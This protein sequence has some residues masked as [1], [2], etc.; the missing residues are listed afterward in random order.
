MTP[1]PESP[2]CSVVLPVF[3]EAATVAELHQRLTSALAQTLQTYEIIYVN[4]GSTDATPGMLDDLAARDSRVSVVHLARNFGQHAALFAG[5]ERVRGEN[6]VT[7]DADLQNPPEEIPK[8]LSRLGADVDVVAGVRSRRRDPWTRRWASRVVNHWVGRMTQ[9]RL[10]DYGCLLRVYRR[11][12]I[13]RLC[14]C[15]ENSVYFTALVAWLG[16]RIVEVDVAHSPRK[17]GR[18]KYGVWKLLRVNFD[19]LTGYSGFPVQVLSVA[20]TIGAAVAF[21]VALAAAP[22][23]VAGAAWARNVALIAGGLGLYLVQ[24]AALGFVGEYV[25]RALLEVKRRP[26]YVLRDELSGRLEDRHERAECER[27]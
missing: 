24:L 13:A 19:L 17:A 21:S 23:W 20:G 1:E 2:Q 26:R 18:S 15:P 4:D 11:S 5:F 8:L 3:N 6:V 7:L 27:S 12:V 16:A 10:R 22:I 14:Q 25:V 9:V